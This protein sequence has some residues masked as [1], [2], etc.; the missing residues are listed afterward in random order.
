MHII[1]FLQPISDHTHARASHQNSKNLSRHIFFKNESSILI[2]PHPPITFK[3]YSSHPSL[4]SISYH[5]PSILLFLRTCSLLQY[6]RSKINIDLLLPKVPLH[7]NNFNHLSTLYSH[8]LCT[9]T[10]PS[11]SV[12]QKMTY[13]NIFFIKK[14][15][16]FVPP[17][18]NTTFLLS[19][20]ISL[21]F[22]PV[23][24]NSILCCA[25]LYTHSR[26]HVYLHFS[27]YW[28]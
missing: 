6:F 15:S 2:Y 22:N 5:F 8:Q 4:F 21:T 28:G 17:F 25:W 14:S 12:S 3:N 10:L 27:I 1:D 23:C 7:V 19:P 26:N 20:Y 24:V 9:S 16:V 18:I 13:L 11:G